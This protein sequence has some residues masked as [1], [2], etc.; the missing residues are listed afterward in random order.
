MGTA[1]FKSYVEYL[2]A[3][4]KIERLAMQYRAGEENDRRGL[5]LYGRHAGKMMQIMSDLT[6]CKQGRDDDDEG[7]SFDDP[8]YKL[9]ERYVQRQY[10]ERAKPFGS[11]L[12]NPGAAYSGTFQSILLSTLAL[13]HTSN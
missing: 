10:G 2:C 8:L 9:I 1:A 3:V 13:I 11:T 12:R 5:A 6:I 7:D 4:Y